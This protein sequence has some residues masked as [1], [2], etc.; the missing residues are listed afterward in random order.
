MFLHCTNCDNQV[1]F[2]PI[3]ANMTKHTKINKYINKEIS[4]QKIIFLAF[5][6]AKLLIRSLYS[7]LSNMSF[8]IDNVASLLNRSSDIVDLKYNFINFNVEKL[9]TSE[10]TVTRIVNNIL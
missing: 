2:S 1:E 10:A 9:L 5:W 4:I 7:N 8:S 3:H 6:E